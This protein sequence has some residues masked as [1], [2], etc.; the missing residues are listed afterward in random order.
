MRIFYS[1]HY[2]LRLVGVSSE[3][4]WY[5]SQRCEGGKTYTERKWYTSR[6]KRGMVSKEAKK[7]MTQLWKA[8][9]QTK[10]EATV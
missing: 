8:G 10:I 1:L 5:A 6:M 4:V 3:A 9:T 7:G 2:N